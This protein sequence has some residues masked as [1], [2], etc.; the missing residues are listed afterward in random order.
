MADTRK[1]QSHQRNVSKPVRWTEPEWDA[2]LAK[3]AA[4]GMTPSEFIRMRALSS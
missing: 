3:S 4:C 1:E 2:V